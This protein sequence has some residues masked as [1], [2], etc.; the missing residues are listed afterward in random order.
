MPYIRT[1][2]IYAENVKPGDA[3]ITINDTIEKVKISAPYGQGWKLVT[4]NGSLTSL[5]RTAVVAVVEINPCRDGK[6]SDL[7]VNDLV[8]IDSV[9]HQVKTIKVNE[10]S[11][12]K[13]DITLMRLDSD[14]AVEVISVGHKKQ[15]SILDK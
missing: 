15:F 3:V 10:E 12:R 8:I 13:L 14:N 6:A 11:K 2:H 7:L 5:H 4:D 9:W 1:R